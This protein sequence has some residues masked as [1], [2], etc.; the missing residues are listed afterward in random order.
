MAQA[1]SLRSG[2]VRLSVPAHGA[3][4]TLVR[5]TTAA[6]AA[7]IN[8]TIDE[9]EDLRI[10]VDEAAALLLPPIAPAAR[11]DV[12]YSFDAEELTITLAAATASSTPPDQSGFGWTVLAALAGSSCAKISCASTCR[13]SNMSPAGSAGGAEPLADLV[14]VGCI[15]LINALDRFEPERSLE[16]TSYAIVGEIKRY[17]RDKG[18][19]VR[20]PRRLQE[21]RTSMAVTVSEL[22]QKLG[23]APTIT[24]LSVALSATEEEIVE[25][26]SPA[27]PAPPCRSRPSRMPNRA[28]RWPTPSATRIRRWNTSNIANRSGRYPHL[29]REAGETARRGLTY[30]RRSSAWRPAGVN[31]RYRTATA[32][33]SRGAA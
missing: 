31:R 33:T 1:D 18:W 13:S 30:I 16:F 25:A 3:F 22:S 4:L 6:V 12:G 5:T 29:G 23:R 32:L 7:R 20:V 11:L 10:S 26:M 9:I 24:E 19:M 14:Q 15:G 17:F 2:E 21:V 28:G 27:T 8:L